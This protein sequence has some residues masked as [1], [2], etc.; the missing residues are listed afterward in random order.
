M[1]NKIYLIFSILLVLF[2]MSI[3]AVGDASNF[4]SVTIT[5]PTST[6]NSIGGTYVFTGTY[7][8][9]SSANISV[10][11]NNSAISQNVP[12]LVCADTTVQTEGTSASPATWTCTG[13]VGSFTEDCTG[14][15][16]N[17]T[18]YSSGNATSGITGNVS[19]TVT[20]VIWD[21]TVPT[22][23]VFDSR[24]K[25][26]M[27]EVRKDHEITV[28]TDDNCDSATNYTATFLK[29]DGKFAVNKSALI[30]V[31]S[32][33]RQ[34]DVDMIGQYTAIV[35]SYDNAM[36]GV[37]STYTFN[38]KGTNNDANVIITQDSVK[39]AQGNNNLLLFGGVAVFLLLAGAIAFIFKRK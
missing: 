13:S 30:T 36:N 25:N 12:I 29:P 16:L 1:K 19:A 26:S 10:Y 14:H 4:T 37:S 28:T 24:Y 11:Y 3:I 34:E 18:A 8:G 17:V 6:S 2:S 23:S 20:T 31:K 9:N 39:K 38:T 35:T 27:Q 5:A 21:N 15:V 32:I 22:L 33:F 7:I